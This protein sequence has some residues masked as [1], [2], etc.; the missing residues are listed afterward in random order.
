MIARRVTYYSTTRHFQRELPPGLSQRD[1]KILMKVKK[2]ARR[3]D[4]SFSMCGVR[5]G[6]T[7]LI[8]KNPL[9]F[10][11]RGVIFLYQA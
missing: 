10:H 9:L 6:W 4:K 7:F 1:E 11:L 8:G 2:R 3:L 5:F